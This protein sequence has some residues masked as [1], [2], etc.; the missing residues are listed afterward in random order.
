MEHNDEILID[1]FLRGELTEVEKKTFQL[2]LEN[3][4]DFNQRFKEME[5]LNA[6]VRVSVLQEK[7]NFLEELEG[8]L[9]SKGQHKKMASNSTVKKGKS[10]GEMKVRRLWWLIATAATII[11]MVIFWPK[12]EV[13]LSQQYAIL[14]DQEFETLIQHDT[15]RSSGFIDPYTKEQRK[16]Y[17]LFVAKEF[18]KAI[19]KLEFLWKNQQDSIAKKYL[20][21]SLIFTGKEELGIKLLNEK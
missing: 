7:R 21:Y 6:G 8:E 16:A 9:F 18:K 15:K 19:P 1:R 2:R 13:K 20:G 17:E 12:E 14:L 10:S 11:G 5:E 3:E 4:K